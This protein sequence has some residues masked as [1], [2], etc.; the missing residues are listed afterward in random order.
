MTGAPVPARMKL[1]VNSEQAQI[2]ATLAGDLCPSGGQDV[3]LPVPGCDGRAT[4]PA[5]RRGRREG[6]ASAAPG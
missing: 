4:T 5:G 6:M 1:A 3:D 2:S